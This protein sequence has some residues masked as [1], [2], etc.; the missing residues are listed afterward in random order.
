MG[1]FYWI[2]LLS[3]WTKC[4]KFLTKNRVKGCQDTHNNNRPEYSLK[5]S[6]VKSEAVYQRTD[7]TMTKRKRTKEKQWHRK[8]HMIF[9]IEQHEPCNRPAAPEGYCWQSK[10]NKYPV[11]FGCKLFYETCFNNLIT[12]WNMSHIVGYFDFLLPLNINIKQSVMF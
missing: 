1:R 4:I 10:I 3:P 5:I 9:T 11:Q 8:Q 12:G 2:G 7:N 6:K